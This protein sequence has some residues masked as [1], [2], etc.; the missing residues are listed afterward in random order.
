MTAT[1]SGD[2]NYATSSG[3]TT[4][5]IGSAALADQLGRPPPGYGAAGDTVDY[6]YLTNDGSDP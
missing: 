6:D 4:V 3:S 1:Y 2:S 5:A